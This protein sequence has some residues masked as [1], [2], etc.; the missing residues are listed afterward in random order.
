LQGRQYSADDRKELDRGLRQ[1]ARLLKRLATVS[2]ALA[3]IERDGSVVKKHCTST[4]S[5]VQTAIRE[6]KE[7]L[8]R[9]E[10]LVLGVEFTAKEA[11]ANLRRLD[12]WVDHKANVGDME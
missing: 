3:M 9:A 10:A 5:E 12:R 11:K 6:Y 2:R 8:N 4:N 7:E 1:R